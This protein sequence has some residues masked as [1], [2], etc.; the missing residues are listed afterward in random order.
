MK[1][2]RN[3]E[4]LKLSDPFEMNSFSFQIKHQSTIDLLNS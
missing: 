4:K 2:L 3:S 1:V